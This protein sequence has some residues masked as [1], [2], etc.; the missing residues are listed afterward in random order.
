MCS[1]VHRVVQGHSRSSSLIAIENAYHFLLV[2][3]SN[4]CLSCTPLLDDKCGMC[5]IVCVVFDSWVGSANIQHSRYTEHGASSA[6]KYCLVCRWL[7]CLR[8][9]CWC[10]ATS[11]ARCQSRCIQAVVCLILQCVQ[12]V[13]SQALLTCCCVTW[14]KWLWPLTFWI[15][16]VSL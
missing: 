5:R 10:P 11:R 15:C 3:T 14:G 4:L 6:G 16:V 1:K 2:V 12:Y 9:T 13:V 7:L 8:T